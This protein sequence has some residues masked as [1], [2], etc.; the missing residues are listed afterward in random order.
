[1]DPIVFH[2]D[3]FSP[4][5]EKVRLVFGR[6]GLSWRSVTI[7]AF[8]PKPDLVALTGGYRHTPVM[9]IGAEVFCDTRRMIT[10]LDRRFPQ[11]LVVD[12][13]TAGLAQAVEAWA[14]RDLF[15]PL[16]R[17]V[18]GINAEEMGA[19]LHADRAMLRGKG[20]VPGVAKLEAVAQRSLPLVVAGTARVENMLAGGHPFLLGEEVGLADLAAYHG[21]WFLSALPVDCS[22][23]LDGFPR[24]REWMAR[25]ATI[26]HGSS[27]ALSSAEALRIAAEASPPPAGASHPGPSD[28]PLGAPV[29]LRPE[30]YTTEETSGRLVR[31]AIDEI[32]VEREDPSLG[33][34]RV[35]FPRTGYALR[36]TDQVSAS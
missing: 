27:T 14:E 1:M 24:V 23:V 25:I 36:V 19:E 21:F 6:K 10:E 30:E 8:L 18:S 4:F 7:P 11:R 5:S 34:I 29:S 9:Q 3:D 17:H 2:H 31:V 13:K 26:G 33:A 12:P 28:P 16:A 22:A 15:W 35:H 32:S 20:S